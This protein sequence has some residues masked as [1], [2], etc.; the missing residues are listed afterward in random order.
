MEGAVFT[1]DA[2]GDHHGSGQL[3]L[4][5]P[6]DALPGPWLQFPRR[7]EKIYPGCTGTKTIY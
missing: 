1:H 7:G 2:A 6:L 3:Q 4:R 5:G